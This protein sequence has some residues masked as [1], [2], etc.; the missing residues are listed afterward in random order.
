M[1]RFSAKVGLKLMPGTALLQSHLQVNLSTDTQQEESNPVTRRG[2]CRNQLGLGKGG[3][4]TLQPGK[5][6][7]CWIESCLSVM[8]V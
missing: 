2:N 5:K 1:L 4:K 7:T 6:I 3:K 8:V